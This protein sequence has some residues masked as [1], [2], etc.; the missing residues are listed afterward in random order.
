MPGGDGRVQVLVAVPTMTG[1]HPRLAAQMLQWARRWPEERLG[2]FMTQGVY[3]HDRARNRIVRHF[4][5]A[6]SA[7]HLM[8]IDSDMIPPAEAI[9]R[10]LAHRQ[11]FV[12]GMTPLAKADLAGHATHVLDF[13]FARG[14]A[15]G[16]PLVQVARNSGL[17]E[18]ERCGAGC[19]ML[20]RGLVEPMHPPWFRF[21]L[22][23][24]GTEIAASEDVGFCDRLRAE[25]HRLY[26]DTSVICRH[27]KTLLL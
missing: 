3:P 2:F 10:L 6:T 1:L 17:V 22:N 19:L 14:E 20:E 7:T 15:P 27:E 16:A 12:T 5:S 23:A 24:D 11:G 21:V 13:C 25:G 4:L 18:I 26:A 8:M 9:D